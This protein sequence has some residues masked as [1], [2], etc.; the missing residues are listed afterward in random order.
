MQT[1]FGKLK[2]EF[3]IC[4]YIEDD[5]TSKSAS[6][7]SKTSKIREIFCVTSHTKSISFLLGKTV[8]NTSTGSARSKQFQPVLLVD[9]GYYQL[10]TDIPTAEIFSLS[11]TTFSAKNLI[12]VIPSFLSL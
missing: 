4:A 12:H 5:Q 11:I 7:A 1:K 6:T 10:G 2:P 8:T 3:S 9:K